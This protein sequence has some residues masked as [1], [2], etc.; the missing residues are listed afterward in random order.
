[1]QTSCLSLYGDAAAKLRT[2]ATFHVGS[3]WVRG[4]LGTQTP[5]VVVVG[6]FPPYANAGGLVPTAGPDGDGPAGGRSIVGN[7]AGFG[8]GGA[9]L[10]TGGGGGNTGNN[11]AGPPNPPAP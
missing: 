2:M 3:C 7:V 9:F 11:D 1:M 10:T 4:K 8:T 6:S 5:F